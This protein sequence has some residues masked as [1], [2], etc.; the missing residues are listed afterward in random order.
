MQLPL[1]INQYSHELQRNFI[2]QHKSSARF[3]RILNEISIIP[4]W[5]CKLREAFIEECLKKI[6]FSLIFLNSFY[7][8]L[9]IFTICQLPLKFR[10]INGINRF[11]IRIFNKNVRKW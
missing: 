10:Q 4:I 3:G 7:I 2:E 1:Q 11:C 9:Q 5:R 8:I 6:Y